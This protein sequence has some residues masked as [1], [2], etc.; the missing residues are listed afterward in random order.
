[1]LLLAAATLTEAF[2]V[3][4]VNNPLSNGSIHQFPIKVHDTVLSAPLT[5]AQAARC[6]L[7]PRR[8]PNNK[9]ADRKK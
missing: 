4:A 8:F 9:H 7:R 2:L 3:V 1:M 6:T 5:A